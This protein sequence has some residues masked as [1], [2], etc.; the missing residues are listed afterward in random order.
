MHWRGIVLRRLL[1]LAVT[2]ALLALCVSQ[3]SHAGQAAQEGNPSIVLNRIVAVVNGEMITFI[4]LQRYGNPEIVRRGLT[5]QGAEAEKAREKVYR[6]VLDT[7]VTD[8]L[9]RQEAERYQIKVSDSEI[10]NE[11]TKYIQR[12]QM[13]RKDFE[14]QLAI[15]G[16]SPQ[17][18]K[19][20]IKDSILRQ[21]LVGMI[22]ARKINVDE[23]EIRKYYE[24]NKSEFVKQDNVK[25]SMI[26]FKPGVKGQNILNSI[27]NG[28]TS[29]EAAAKKYST[30]PT[31]SKGG[32]MGSVPWTE[33]D[34]S[35]R[36]V[37]SKMKPGEVSN[38]F[39]AGNADVILRLDAP[40]TSNFMSYE[41]ASPRIEHMLREPLLD[42]AYKEYATR[43][44][45]RA[46]V[47]I[48]M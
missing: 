45:Q 38:V 46:V 40:L 31:A 1:I 21:R 42:K 7:L 10:E 19:E 22:I 20:R 18:L 34:E 48:R 27:K 14:A 8:I 5:K 33:L 17:Q 43:L 26:L 11:Y 36:K 32:D 4:D 30:A 16:S 15:Q 13:N 35:W 25:F 24:E 29:F 41:E 9:L 12:L 6:E 2:A 23:A 28:K 3:T 39:K 44:R 47:E 37:L